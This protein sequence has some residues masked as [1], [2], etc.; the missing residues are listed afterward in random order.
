[1]FCEALDDEG[2]D[3]VGRSI[4]GMGVLDGGSGGADGGD[5]GPVFGTGG[6]GGDPLFEELNLERGKGFL[7]FGRGHDEAGIGVF[8]PANH[9]A[10]GG[11]SGHDGRLAA[12]AAVESGLVGIESEFGLAC[13]VIAAVAVPA[14]VGKDGAN[15]AVVV[16]CGFLFGGALPCR[17]RLVEENKEECDGRHGLVH[18]CGGPVLD[19]W[20]CVLG[21]E[22]AEDS[23]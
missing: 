7:S 2:I 9:F 6:A 22:P 12:G 19:V 18:G 23:G 17:G 4:Q 5:E 11:V 16:D 21:K 1:M 14:M 10:G 13:S 3:W 15:I 20:R 8:D